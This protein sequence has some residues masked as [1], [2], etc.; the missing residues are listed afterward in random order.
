MGYF[1]VYKDSFGD[2][3]MSF[4]YFFVDG[5]EKLY[6]LKVSLCHKLCGEFEKIKYLFR[7][8]KK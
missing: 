2:N 1:Y 3:K 7:K 4:D 6:D 5:G 8:S